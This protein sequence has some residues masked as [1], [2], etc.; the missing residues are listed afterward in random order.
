MEGCRVRKGR[1]TDDSSTRDTFSYR[2][3]SKRIIEL[4]RILVHYMVEVG[5]HYGYIVL[6]IRSRTIVE[7]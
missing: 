3:V 6:E 5:W 1:I 7:V 4:C 2:T